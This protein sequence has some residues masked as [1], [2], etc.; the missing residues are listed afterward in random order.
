MRLNK[1]VYAITRDLAHTA[2]MVREVELALSTGVACVQY[3]NKMADA[4][5]MLEQAGVLRALCAQYK[6]P[7]IINDNV[8]LAFAV[9]ADGVHLGGEDGS[10]AQARSVLGDERI[11]GASC[12]ADVDLARNAVTDGADYVAFG[13]VFPSPTK[14]NAPRADFEII[15]RGAELGV[16]VVA[17][18]GITPD[19]GRA[20][21]TAGASLIAAI[22]GIFGSADVAANVQAYRR[23]FGEVSK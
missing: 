12:Y 7:L 2:S 3:R 15:H 13:A 22:S 5:L 18:G 4:S 14:P 19:N 16:P 20:V 17:I 1:G 6:T 9:D 11:I 8:A 23:C 21:V 10:I